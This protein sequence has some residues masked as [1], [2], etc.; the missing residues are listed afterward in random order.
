MT[1]PLYA[2]DDLHGYL[3]SVVTDEMICKRGDAQFD[4]LN[5]EKDE[6]QLRS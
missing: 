1:I 6:Y 4:I 5:A 2:T 3:V